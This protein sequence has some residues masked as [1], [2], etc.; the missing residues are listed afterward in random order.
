M[1]GQL[2]TTMPGSEAGTLY[3]AFIMK[4][5]EAGDELGLSFTDTSGRLKGVVPILQEIKRQFPDLS[6]AAAQVKL[7]KAFGSD[8]AVKFLLQMSAGM[9]SLEGNIQSVGRAMKTGTAVTEQMADAMNQDI[10]ARFLLLRQQVA[11]LSEILGRTLLPVVTP[12]INGVSRFILFLQRMAKSMSGVTRVILGLSMALGTILVV[13]GAVTAAVGMV[14]LMLPAIKA[15]F[16]AISAALAGVGSAVATYFLPVTAIIAGVILSVYLLKRAWET[17]FGGIQEIITGAWNKVSLV[18]R[19]IRELVGSLSGGVGQMSAELAQ[20]LESAGLLGFVVTVFKAYYRVREALAGL[21]GAFS[22][23]FGRIRAILEPTVRTLMSAYAAL[24]SAVFSVV[25]IFGVAASA[26]DGSSWRTFG[27]VIGT[28]AGVLLQGLAFA[29]KIVAWNLSLIVRALAVVVRSVVWVGKIIVGSLVG[30]AKFIYKFLLPVHMIGE[31]FMAAGKIVYSVW[32][33][34]T[35]DISLLDGL[36][37][38]GGAVYDFLATPFRWARDVVVGVWN[39]ISGIFTSIGRLVADAAG[40]IGQAILNLPIIST[41]REMLATVRSFFAGDTTFFEAG[42]KLLVTLGE[43]IW[44]AVTYPFTMLKNALGKLRN[45]LPFS[46]AREGPL[47]SLT[48]S[49]SALLKT[50]ADGMSLTQSLPAKV[51]GFAARGILSAAAGAWQQIKSAG[52]NLMDA[53][54][55]PFRMAGKFWDGLTTG[56]QSVAAKAG[57]IFGGLKQSLFGDTPELAI[58][59]PRVNAWDAL[60]TGAVTVRDRIVATLSAVPGAVGRIFSNAGAEGQT[61]WQRL[62]SGA[63]AGIQAIKDRSAGIANSLLSSARAML[64]IQTPIPQVAEQKQ[65]LGAAQPAESIGQR[66]IENVLSLVP[67][68]DER[69]VPKALSAMLMLQPV[70]AS[71]APPP[72][73]MNGTV[74]TVAAAVEPVSKSYIQPFAM[75]PALEKGDASLAPAGIDLPITAAPTPIAKPLQSGLAETVPSERLIAPA[76]T[77]PSTPMR[78]EEA[79][80]GLR[81]LLESLLSRLDGLADRP[82]ELSVTTNIDGRKV[83]EAVYKDLRERKIRNYETL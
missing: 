52:G 53:A 19:G 33:V 59:P 81:E 48:A 11:N 45:L 74:Q 2:Q 23:A 61:L 24:A 8:E 78:G 58:T 4:A 65:P 6:N 15:G 29:L 64:G 13:A 12:V 63:S 14:G 22:H 72:Q 7:K 80:P 46:D 54:S 62:S 38:I 17:N 9:E 42:K 39:F 26:T 70:M 27:T 21:W 34:L 56:A 16:V 30:A 67:R 20:K 3:K 83:A 5:A 82:V 10:G 71:A 32:Q 55:A 28:V 50:L 49:G 69:L 43:G 75:E 68:L 40:Q 60:A 37:A 77:A 35:G 18:F 1:L 44:S 41:L 25:E 36:K 47:A 79:G 66:I 76:R 51:F 73:P 57:A 31:A